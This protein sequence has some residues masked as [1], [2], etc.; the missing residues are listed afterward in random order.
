MWALLLTSLLRREHFAGLQKKKEPSKLI[1]D[2]LIKATDSESY[3][4][5]TRALV[6]KQYDATSKMMA[7]CNENFGQTR[8][9]G[10]TLMDLNPQ[11]NPLSD[12]IPILKI[13]MEFELSPLVIYSG[14]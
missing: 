3:F 6:A 13:N 4:D 1:K 11:K 12:P 9:Q 14:F 8:L 10:V 5:A 7:Y 2:P